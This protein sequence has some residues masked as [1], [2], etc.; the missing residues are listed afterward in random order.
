MKIKFDLSDVLEFYWFD[1]D[2]STIKRTGLPLDQIEN[3]PEQISDKEVETLVEG[4]V[5]RIYINKHE[6]NPKARRICI[7][8]YGTVCQVC[9][10]DFGK[11]YGDKFLGRI[12]VHHL[13]PL[14]SIAAEYQIDPIH[15]LIP[16]CPNCHLVIHSKEEEPYTVEEVRA[17][18]V[19]K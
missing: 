1:P 18:L 7:Q 8:H 14:N 3:I 16:I 11:V 2:T 12:E 10:F 19:K 15:H 9:G 13:I 6:R 5:I 17:M 4:A